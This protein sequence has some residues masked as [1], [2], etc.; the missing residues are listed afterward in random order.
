MDIDPAL[1]ASALRRQAEI[2][3]SGRTAGQARGN[4]KRCS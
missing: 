4:Q 2:M 3:M 1:L